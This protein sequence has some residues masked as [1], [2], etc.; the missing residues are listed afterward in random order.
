MKNQILKML[1]LS[2]YRVKTYARVGY[3]ANIKKQ[4]WQSRIVAN[5]QPYS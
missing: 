1:V 2:L 5:K 3:S 4:T